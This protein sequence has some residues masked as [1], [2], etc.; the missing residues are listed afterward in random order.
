MGDYGSTNLRSR[1]CLIKSAWKKSLKHGLVLIGS[2]PMRMSGIRSQACWMKLMASSSEILAKVG[3]SLRLSGEWMWMRIYFPILLPDLW[4]TTWLP[5]ARPK[6]RGLKAWQSTTHLF[7][8]SLLRRGRTRCRMRYG[9]G[10]N[11]LPHQVRL[12]W[13]TL[14]RLATT[15]GSFG[16]REDPADLNGLLKSPGQTSPMAAWLTTCAIPR[17]ASAR[18]A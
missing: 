8:I 1:Q 12:P 7:G 14:E 10:Y 4:R 5:T 13:V 15:S 9:G 6:S 2:Q 11:L 3:N 16:D 17:A 18:S